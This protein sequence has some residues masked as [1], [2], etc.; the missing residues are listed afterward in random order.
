M[1]RE[2]LYILIALVLIT[3]LIGFVYYR[4]ANKSNKFIWAK[5]YRDGIKNPYDFGRFKQMLKNKARFKELHDEI[6]ESL[7]RDSMASGKTYLFVGG[8]LYLDDREIES[9]LRSWI[10]FIIRVF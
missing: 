10:S 3:A 9:L 1:R 8:D 5:T 7:D 6:K 4:S 2:R